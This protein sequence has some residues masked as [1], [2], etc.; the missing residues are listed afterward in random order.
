MDTIS[1]RQLPTL[2]F[3]SK[4]T[5]CDLIFC[6]QVIID[7]RALGDYTRRRRVYIILIH[8]KVAIDKVKSHKTL[9]IRCQE[10]LDKLKEPE[11]TLDPFLG[12]NLGAL[13]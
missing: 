7:P 9:E 3:A 5:C 4:T 8:R 1:A 2:H 12:F 13:T 10:T 11:V 6:W